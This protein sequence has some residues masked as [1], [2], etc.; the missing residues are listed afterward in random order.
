MSGH[1][2]IRVIPTLLLRGKGLVKTQRFKDAVY[3]GDPINAIRIFNDKE[4]DELV[5]LDITATPS[6]KGPDLAMLRTVVGECFMPFCYG[7]GVHGLAQVEQILKVGV[8]KV[9]I[10]TALTTH[11]DS[12]REA[13]KALGS[14]T[15]VGAIDFKRPLIGR[16]TAWTHAGTQNTKRPV[17][18]AAK[19]AEDL[20]VGELY[21]NSI[22]RDGTMGGYDLEVIRSVTEAVRIPVIASGGAGS[23]ADFRA[24]V[25]QGGA[26]AVSAGA[27][28]VLHGKHRA[29]LITY[30]SQEELAREVFT[31]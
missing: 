27:F 12:V 4:V 30:P 7:G 13:T 31:P 6:G 3:V 11:P 25:V 29:V 1:R 26:S 2:R 22:E 21:L 14:S 17:V 8:E 19:R 15:I 5:L 9:A 23:L 18:E 16:P 20:G 10:N 24:A 28:F